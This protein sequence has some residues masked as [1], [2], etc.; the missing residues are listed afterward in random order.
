MSKLILPDGTNLIDKKQYVLTVFVLNVEN[1]L[2][3]MEIYP[4]PIQKPTLIPGL[5]EIEHKGASLTQI[6]HYMQSPVDKLLGAAAEIKECKVLFAVT[7]LEA[8]KEQQAKAIALQQVQQQI[9][10]ITA[11]VIEEKG[12]NEQSE[13][14]E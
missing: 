3:P 9:A 5:M 7:E 13:Q 8:F 12:T 10:N 6:K 4:Q 11:A 14:S 1:K 2:I